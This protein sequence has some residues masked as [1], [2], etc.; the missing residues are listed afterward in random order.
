[1]LGVV[2]LVRTQRRG[3]GFSKRRMHAYGRVNTYVR[4]HGGGGGSCRLHPK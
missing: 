3:E 2:H 1:M 4:T